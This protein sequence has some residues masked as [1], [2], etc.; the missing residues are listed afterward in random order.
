MFASNL[1]FVLFGPVLL[2]QVRFSFVQF[3]PGKVT[4]NGVMLGLYQARLGFN[5]HSSKI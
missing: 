5:L 2:G 3:S 1:G 4:G